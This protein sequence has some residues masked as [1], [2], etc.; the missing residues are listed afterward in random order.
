M[1]KYKGGNRNN[2]NQVREDFVIRHNS[3]LGP[4]ETKRKNDRNKMSL[5]QP[6][7]NPPPKK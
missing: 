2:G 5:S 4:G 7:N 3:T 1:C 6:G